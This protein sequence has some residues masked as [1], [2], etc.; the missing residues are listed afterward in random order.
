MRTESSALLAAVATSAMFLSSCLTHELQDTATTAAPL[1]VASA[2]DR[3]T[4]EYIVVFRDDVPAAARAAAHDLV[5]QAGPGNR[6]IHSYSVIP[7]FQAALDP[8]LLAE[9]RRR[10][11]VAYIQENAAVRLHGIF[12][13]AADGVD[14]L[15][16]RL[17]RD[18]LYNDHGRTG[19][20]VHIYVVDTGINT[21]HTEFTGRI[22]IGYTAMLDGRGV[23]DC[24]GHGTLVSSIAAG[25]DYGVA[26]QARLHPVRV[27]NCA[28][29]T[30]LGFMI[31]GLDWAGEN[32][33]TQT[34]RCVV[35]LSLGAELAPVLNQ[36]VT[37]LI[38]AGIP[39]VTSAG[40]ET[41]DA[42]LLSPGSVPSVITVAGIDDA[43]T[44]IASSNFGT[45]VD[46]F[47]PGA[48]ILGAYIG[49]RFATALGDG[50][51]FAAPHVTGVVAQY[52]SSNPTATPAQVEL[53]VKGSASLE[54]V[55]NPRGSPNLLVFNDLSQGNFTCPS[56]AE[57]CEGLCGEPS[58]VCYCDPGCV[59]FGD[60][61]ADYAHF[62][63]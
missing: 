59:E 54:C 58:G 5:A 31:E 35:N 20:G 32:C 60:C 6:V 12:N 26:R 8:A 14:R 39:V 55:D 49:N 4:G 33:P 27:T 53:N 28:G 63:E 21:V 38:N 13:T 19:A 37:N 45:C 15:D 43:D 18:G 10:P 41:R 46:M 36:A 30:N 50:T 22:G 11:D 23:E 48:S 34:G 57:S 2:A 56:G 62:C 1:V 24:H 7:G 61:C 47:A 44:R 51:S 25:T 40:D 3:V 29:Q 9:L 17:G 52:L 42:C 16:Q